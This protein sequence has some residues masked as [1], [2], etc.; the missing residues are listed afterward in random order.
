[1]LR[2]SLQTILAVVT[3]SCVSI[4]LVAAQEKKAVF[5]WMPA[6][7]EAQG[8]TQQGVERLVETLRERD[9][10]CLLIVR[11]DKVVCEWYAPDFGPHKKHY[12]ASLAKA[13]VGG[14]SL[15]LALNDGLIG[16]DDPA[17]KYITQWQGDSTREGVT[18]RH[19]ATHSS[20]V[21]D[22]HN[23][24]LGHFDIG[25]WKTRFWQREPDPFTISRDWAPMSFKPGTGYEYSN[26][27]MALLS[28]CITAA[29]QGGEHQDVRTL[30]RERIMRPIGVEDDDWSIGYGKTYSVD[31]MD[32]VA[33]WGGG[34]FTARAVARI[35]RLMLRR[36]DWDGRRLFDAKWG[37]LVTSDAGTPEPY[38]GPGE[39]PT[40]R[41]GLA[42][43]VNSDGVLK[44]L[45][46]DAFMGAGAGNQ[47]LIVIPSMNMVVVRMGGQMQPDSF[48]GGIESCLVNPLMDAASKTSLAPYP[49][50]PV[51]K[52]I[53]WAPMDSITRKAPGGDNWPITWADDGALY[54]AYGDGFG[55]E[56]FVEKKLSLGLV[57]VSGTPGAFRGEN[58]RSSDIEQIGD[59]AKGKK[60]SGLLMIDGVLY[61]LARNADNA[62]LAWSEDYGKTWQWAPWTFETSF[63][64]PTF[65]QFGK[66]YA[67]ARDEYVYLVSQDS[68]SAY[69]TSDRMVMARVH[70]ANIKDRKAYE[71]F[72][73]LDDAGAPLWTKNLNQRG[74]MFEHP[75]R[76]YRSGITYNAGLKRYLWCQTLP[77]AAPRFSGGFGIYDA[78]E[79][80]GPWTTVY[81]TELWDVGPGETSSFPP[82]WMSSDGQTCHLVFSGD[83]A[84]SVRKAVMRLNN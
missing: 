28:Y 33:N 4:A 74:A 30:L 55:F 8:F 84:F 63:G 60:A 64:C 12:S 81:F 50:S 21:A 47:I 5:D 54:T 66:N 34:A 27:G 77:G 65:V 20:G 48:W 42:W 76:C 10:K 26:P 67:K 40:P 58:L 6:L 29:L 16:V 46:K 3:L 62:Q 75:G 39:G 9:T 61:L 73:G 70:Q 13:L 31:G 80:W 32:M 53:E 38:R 72:Q 57:K 78:P 1:M 69:E 23:D 43:W 18:I 41:A 24:S 37:R 35:G 7:P 44:Q 36:G 68:D 11:N 79:P 51:I 19:L 82:A 14:M 49:P 15:L 22:A 71:F 52:D 2:N 83:D 45:P 25:G 56:P 17:E 59:G